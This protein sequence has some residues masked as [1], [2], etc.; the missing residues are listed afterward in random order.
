LENKRAFFSRYIPWQNVFQ[1][2]PGVQPLSRTPTP[3]P[4]PDPGENGEES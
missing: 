3:E 1:Y 4:T 2:G